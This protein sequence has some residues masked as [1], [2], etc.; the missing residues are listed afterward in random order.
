MRVLDCKFLA[1]NAATGH[2]FSLGNIEFFIR[3]TLP[4]GHFIPYLTQFDI[5]NAIFINKY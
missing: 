1:A 2:F 3:K 5:K 4:R